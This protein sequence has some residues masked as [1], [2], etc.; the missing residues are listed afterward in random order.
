MSN[1]LENFD[2]THIIYVV[3]IIVLIIILYNIY[4]KKSSDEHYSEDDMSTP[5]DD[6]IDK[7]VESENAINPITSPSIDS[8]LDI[9]WANKAADG[10]Y[11]YSSYAGGIRG[12]DNST[13]DALDVY[14]SPLA[15]SIDYSKMDSN[16]EY[17]SFDESTG[18]YAPYEQKKTKFSTDEL[19]DV[20]KLL[21]QEV[22]KDWF[23]LMP[24]AI[25]VKNRHLI[26]IA[27]P[28]GTAS[29]AGSLRN[30]SHDI[31]GDIPNPKFVVS[32]F[33]NSTIEP[34][35]YNIGLCNS[36]RYN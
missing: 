16:D 27:R 7:L 13:L 24:D 20:D 9:K 34:N 23:E 31:R 8:G 3:V 21:P 33:M 14:D 32:P 19:F 17:K 5:I 2:K 15:N 11:V 1:F 28:I 25:K 10:K 36:S 29:I 6:E 4:F 30:A 35:V 18:Q 26:N 22:N 12:N